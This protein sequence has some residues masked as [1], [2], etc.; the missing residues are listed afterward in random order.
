[1]AAQPEFPFDRNGAHA[2]VIGRWCVR[3]Y[4][5]NPD[6]PDFTWDRFKVDTP[7]LVHIYRATPAHAR[8]L[9]ENWRTGVRRFRAFLEDG[10]GNVVTS[11]LC[12]SRS[13]RITSHSKISSVVVLITRTHRRLPVRVPSRHRI[14]RTR[15]E[16]RTSRRAKHQPR[17]RRRFR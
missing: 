6:D 5:D 15:A 17:R 1:M 9:K 2:A 4:N 10:Q 11:Q 7:D 13:K 3:K 16:R 12:F 14:A 8:R